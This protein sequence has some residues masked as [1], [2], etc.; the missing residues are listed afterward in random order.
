MSQIKVIHIIGNS[1]ALYK[2]SKYSIYYDDTIMDIKRKIILNA[3]LDGNLDVSTE[4]IYLFGKIENSEDPEK[5]FTLLTKNKNMV[6]IPSADVE[7]LEK[8]YGTLKKKKT[9]S[10]I[11]YKDFKPLF[12]WKKVETD[13]TLGHKVFDKTQR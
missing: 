12:D 8:N 3:N 6:S 7:I 13:K 5:I 11:Y 10:K 2:S 4:E 1:E 9:Q